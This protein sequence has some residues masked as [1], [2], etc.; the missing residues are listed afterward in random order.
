[1]PS[2]WRS[3]FRRS[4]AWGRA[5]LLR[6]ARVLRVVLVKTCWALG[7]IALV[8]I[9]LA[10]TRVPYDAH[11]WLGT[12]AGGCTEAPQAIVV[13][14]GSGMPS[15]PELLRLDHAAELAQAWPD[16]AVFVVHP[17]DPAV[18]QLMADELVQKGVGPERI[19]QVHEGDNTRAQAMA[20]VGR[21]GEERPALAVVTAP[22]NVYR[23]VRA[24][25]KVGFDHVCGA[26]AWDN[27]MDHAF[28]YGHRKIG[29]KAY[30][31]DVSDNLAVR[32]NFWNYLKLEITCLRE[33]AAIAYYALNGWI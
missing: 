2:A 6:I 10:F 4:L 12:A 26:P 28:T 22:E 14:G 7:V 21:S 18:I 25:R 24:F 3:R 8:M 1:M 9:V 33:Y 17:G 31:P 23:T 19:V 15:G 32:Y 13:L 30:V 5:G 16:A 11:R 27:P 29:G 20:V